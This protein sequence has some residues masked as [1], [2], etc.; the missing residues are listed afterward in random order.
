MITVETFFIIHF[1]YHPRCIDV[2]GPILDI[3][4]YF[5]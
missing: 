5:F 3:V 1:G 2:K 4:T